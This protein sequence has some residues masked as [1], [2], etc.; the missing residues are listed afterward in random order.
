VHL[1]IHTPKR[2]HGQLINY[3]NIGTAFPGGKAAEA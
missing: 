2:F 3:L 1:W